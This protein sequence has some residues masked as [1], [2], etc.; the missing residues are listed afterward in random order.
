MGRGL[1]SAPSSAMEMLEDWTK[2]VPPG[3][4]SQMYQESDA[5]SAVRPLEFMAGGPNI[6][7]RVRETWMRSQFLS[8]WLSDLEQVP[9]PPG[10][11][12]SSSEKCILK[13]SPVLSGFS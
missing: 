5:S 11:S 4:V 12:V 3:P 1:G 2:F 8:Y 13:P 7:L 6:G 10:A 9:P